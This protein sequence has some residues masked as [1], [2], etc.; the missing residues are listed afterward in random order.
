MSD[1]W[2][3]QDY[4]L[5]MVSG[6]DSDSWDVV[7]TNHLKPETPIAEYTGVV[8]AGNPKRNQKYALPVYNGFGGTSRMM[9]DPIYIDSSVMGNEM[10][11]VGHGNEGRNCTFST[12][13]VR[14]EVKW[15]I[16]SIKHILPGERL[17]MFYPQLYPV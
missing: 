4:R 12:W 10:R 5:E 16:S 11:F 9:A 3:R 13:V 2:E 7:A 6:S 15:I 14:D 1:N 8:R 17:T